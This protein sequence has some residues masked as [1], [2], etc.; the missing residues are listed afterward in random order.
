VIASVPWPDDRR[1]AFTVIDDPD[2]QSLGMSTEVYALLRDLGFRTT[3]AVWVMEP[4]ERNSFGDT[5]DSPAFRTHCHDLQRNGF[6]IAYHNAA[7][8]TVGRADVLRSLDLFRDYFGH[9]PISMANHYN[10]DAIYWGEARLTGGWRRLYRAVTR[11]G[12]RFHGHVEGHPCFWGDLCR[13]RIRY[14]RNFVFRRV[15]TLAACPYMPYADPD[16]PYVRSWYA[17]SEGHDRDAFVRQLSE[18]EQDRL[19]EEGGACIVYT[20]FGHGFVHDGHLDP[21]FVR[22]MTRLAGKGGWFVPVS[23][24]LDHLRSLRGVHELTARERSR[25]ERSWFAAKLLYGTS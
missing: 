24:L 4:P 12:N 16:R 17:A 18:R 7:P 14:C 5:C 1:F 2:G 13:E 19:E 21:E 10:D 8:G 3:K 15:N 9:D 23:A 20:H 11:G 6:E 25:L 22:L